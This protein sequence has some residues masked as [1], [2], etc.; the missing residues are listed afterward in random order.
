M[1]LDWLDELMSSQTANIIFNSKDHSQLWFVTCWK[2]GSKR[3]KVASFGHEVRGPQ[4]KE[5]KKK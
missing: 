4:A 2:K 5:C 3:Y 1:I